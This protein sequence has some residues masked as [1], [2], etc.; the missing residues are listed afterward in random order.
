M[1]CS[2]LSVRFF[3]IV[4]ATKYYQ[5]G[6]KKRQ[7]R[8]FPR[9]K[10]NFS[11]KCRILHNGTQHECDWHDIFL[12]MK[13]TIDVWNKLFG[14]RTFLAFCW[15]IPFFNEDSF[16]IFQL[17]LHTKQNKKLTIYGCHWKE[18]ALPHHLV[19][20]FLHSVQCFTAFCAISTLSLH[21]LLKITLCRISTEKR[22]C[23]SVISHLTSSQQL[24]RN[25]IVSVLSFLVSL[26]LWCAYNWTTFWIA[27]DSGI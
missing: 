6:K 25:S 14:I 7:W 26:A 11:N 19:R 22:L 15:H 4:H 3:P 13:H 21:W 16:A 5:R 10:R 17:Q 27:N 24:F 23:T 2:L 12:Y 20:F 9:D 18:I 8:K 1:I